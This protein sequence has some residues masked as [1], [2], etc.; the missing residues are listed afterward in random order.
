MDIGN[1]IMLE[2]PSRRL[3]YT[4]KRGIWKG[5]WCARPEKVDRV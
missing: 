3:A 4:Y 2:Q 1:K 5:K